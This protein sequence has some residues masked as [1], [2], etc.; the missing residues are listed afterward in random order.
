MNAHRPKVLF[1][2]TGNSCRSQMA[3]GWAKTMHADILDAYSAGTSPHG[4]NTSAVKVMSEVG[5]DIS[6]QNS[7]H[8]DSLSEIKFDLIVTVCDSAAS[9]CPIPPTGTRVIHAPFQDPP[10]LAT[11]AK[12]ED[13]ALQPYRRVRD[14]IKD[15]ILKLPQLIEC[16]NQ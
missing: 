7:K 10:Q 11:G 6:G 8:I 2:C 12:S 15:F 16:P 14:E 13:E 5:I 1:L 4:I 3:E 9:N